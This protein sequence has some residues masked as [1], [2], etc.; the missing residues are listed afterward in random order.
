MVDLETVN[1]VLSLIVSLLPAV[2]WYWIS[3]LGQSRG[4]MF[5][6]A[7]VQPGF[8][9]SNSGQAILK[10]FRRRLW[11]WCTSVAAA[12]ILLPVALALFAGSLLSS[13]AGSIAFAMANRRTQREAK[14]AV[15]TA[16]RIASL[17]VGTE[18]D[19]WWLNGLDWVSMLF[20]PLIP[21]AALMIMALRSSDVRTSFHGWQIF[22]VFF[23]LGMGL[24]CAANHWALRFRARTS[25]WAPTRSASHK[26]RTYLGAMQA[27]IFSF[28]ICQ[29]C[30][31]VLSGAGGSVAFLRRVNV[32]DFRVILPVEIVWLGCVWRMRFWLTNHMSRE[33]SDPMSDTCWKWGHFYFNPSDPALV[34]PMRAGPL[35]SYNYAR[36]SVW[37]VSGIVM[38]LT[39]G[40]VAES[41]RLLAGIGR[42]LPN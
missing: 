15:T 8:I 34:V 5:F 29:L 18:A 12:S 33:S 23:S 19:A 26:Y 9:E 20:P 11:W 39:I 13:L 41:I 37:V 25:D 38:A 1:R 21:T 28:L 31:P 35:Q 14:V 4:Q 40:M 17:V 2:I 10:E 32:L 24:M 36:A 22:S 27:L 42:Y 30:L 6:G 16:V 7:H 3:T